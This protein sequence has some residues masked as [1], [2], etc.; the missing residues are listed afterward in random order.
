MHDL[1]DLG[2]Y[3]LRGQDMNCT[4]RAPQSAPDFL[5]RGHYGGGVYGDMMH[6]AEYRH[7][8]SIHRRAPAT[9]PPP[10]PTD[11]AN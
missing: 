11:G 7:A 4:I 9:P 6:I 5:N 3:G 2:D 10:Q 8:Q 1:S